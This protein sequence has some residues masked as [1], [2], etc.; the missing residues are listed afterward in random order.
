MA[1]VCTPDP[2]AP[3]DSAQAA[4][5][6]LPTPSNAMAHDFNN[7]LGAMM[8]WIHLARRRSTDPAID[9]LL[10]RALAAGERGKLLTLCL[11][12]PPGSGDPAMLPVNAAVPPCTDRLP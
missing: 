8:G 11:L 3:R 9:A 10:E 1:D 7:I 2:A 6:P 4:S 5:V 12:A